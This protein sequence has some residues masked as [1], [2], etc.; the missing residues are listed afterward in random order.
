MSE[1]NFKSEYCREIQPREELTLIPQT[2]ARRKVNCTYPPIF[3]TR[4]LFFL[5]YLRLAQT[6]MQFLQLSTAWKSRV[7]AAMFQTRE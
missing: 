5:L 6:P 1:N 7:G 3:A 2:G 4:C